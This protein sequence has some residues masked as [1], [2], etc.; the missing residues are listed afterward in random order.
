MEIGREHLCR[1]LAGAETGAHRPGCWARRGNLADVTARL[2]LLGLVGQQP[3]AAKH[4]WPVAA[5]AFAPV[6]LGW[7]GHH[8]PAV[9]VLCR[10][11]PVAANGDQLC[12]ICCADL[13]VAGGSVSTWGNLAPGA[14]CD[15]WLYLGWGVA[16]LLR[17]VRAATSA[18]PNATG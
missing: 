14:L 2:A 13:V 7:C 1:L 16:V 8:L 11:Q 9:D 17:S 4:P 3:G 5:C 18:R 15:F 10:A 6:G 12:A